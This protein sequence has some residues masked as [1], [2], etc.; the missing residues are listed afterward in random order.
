MKN[1]NLTFKLTFF[2]STSDKFSFLN[3]QNSNG[4]K[5]DFVF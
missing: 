3:T 5:L 2:L 1:E 4:I